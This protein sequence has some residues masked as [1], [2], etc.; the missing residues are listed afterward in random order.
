[1]RQVPLHVKTYVH[2]ESKFVDGPVP[3]ELERTEKFNYRGALENILLRQPQ[4]EGIG[5]AEFKFFDAVNRALE[6]AADGYML[7]EEAD[8]DHLCNRLKKFKFTQWSRFTLG[9]LEDIFQAEQ[10]TVKATGEEGSNAA[11]GTAD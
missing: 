8:W 4:P 6:Q 10:V 9:F 3:P 5:Y 11:S 7:L 2:P 1:M